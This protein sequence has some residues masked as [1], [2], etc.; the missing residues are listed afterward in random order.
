MVPFSEAGYSFAINFKVPTSTIQFLTI[1]ASDVNTSCLTA[2]LAPAT[3]ARRQRTPSAGVQ[4]QA[5]GDVR[6]V[7]VKEQDGAVRL[8]DVSRLLSELDSR[9]GDDAEILA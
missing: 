9:R 4:S 6:W 8:I 7:G 2:G 1:K 3:P 5:A